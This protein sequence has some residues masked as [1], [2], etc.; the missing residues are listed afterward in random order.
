MNNMNDMRKNSEEYDYL[1]KIILIGESGVGKTNLLNRY[2]SNDFLKDSK[3][4]VG[5]EFGLKKLNIFGKK[6]SAQIW[7][8]AGQERYKSVT[9]AYYKGTKG[10]VI[11]YDVTNIESFEAVDKW[12]LDLKSKVDF[13]FICVIVGNKCDKEN[14]RKVSKE[15]GKKKAESNS[16]YCKYCKYIN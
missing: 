16:K 10:A 15:D 8:T 6:V 5:V 9:N 4:T 13:D 14:E 12:Y 11:V 1:F 7:D 2:I 3:A